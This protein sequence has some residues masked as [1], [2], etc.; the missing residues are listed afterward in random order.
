MEKENILNLN[1]NE[2]EFSKKYKY[3]L[4]GKEYII[5]LGKLLN[6]DKLG[7]LIKLI[8]PFS[9]IYYEIDIDIYQLKQNHLIFRCY[10]NLKDIILELFEIFEEKKFSLYFKNKNLNLIIEVN[11]GLKG[12]DNISF[13]LE[14]KFLFSKF[15]TELKNEINIL[16]LKFNELEKGK[17]NIEIET[18]KNEIQALKDE[19]NKKDITIRELST[20]IKEIENW[21]KRMEDKEINEKNLENIIDSKIITKKEELNFLLERFQNTEILKKKKITF[22]LLFRATRDGTNNMHFHRKC[23]GIPNTL[24]IIQTTKGYKFG[25]FIESEWNTKDGWVYDN[26]N[27]FMFSLDLMKIYNGIKGKARHCCLSNVGPQFD[28]LIDLGEN[29]FSKNNVQDMKRSNNSYAG[30]TS[31]FETNGGEKYYFPQELEVFQIIFT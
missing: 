3:I 17:K 12:K 19:N 1:I 25:G 16:K 30:F 26:E 18:L 8:S 21:K 27:A 14:K 28:I 24:S 13:Q 23:D 6:K 4:N 7:F 22:K 31:D 9:D 29:M 15:I 2:F 5:E 10:D 11:K 20:K